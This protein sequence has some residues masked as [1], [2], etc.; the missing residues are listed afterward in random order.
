MGSGAS[1]AKA[2]GQALIE[3]GWLQGSVCQVPNG[4][5]VT[6]HVP[7]VAEGDCAVESVSLPTDQ[8]LVIVSQDCDIK[9]A[10]SNVEALACMRSSDR[11][12]LHNGRRN[13]VRTFTITHDESFG[14]GLLVDARRRVILSKTLL[15]TLTP[16]DWPG[17]AA[18]LDRFRRWLA[19]RFDRPAIP[20]EIVESFVDP[21]NK[22]L[23]TL[24]ERRP[25]VMSAFS[26]AIEQIRIRL[27][28]SVSPPHEV[29]LLLLSLVPLMEMP[30]ASADDIVTVM[31][32]VGK[33]MDPG[34]AF[35]GDYVIRGPAEL[36]LEEYRATRPIFLDQ[37]SFRGDEQIGPPPDRDG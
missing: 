15:A 30:R 37:Y 6:R 9:G 24:S 36:S 3:K 33:A 29:N 7:G 21:A 22:A 20:D 16:E 10:E 35:I 26:L 28:S 13:S 2:L 19:H 23:K 27:P 18:R 11:T 32:E 4:L 5:R 31:D 1:A 17:D 12:A 14:E 25:G 8:F 34:L